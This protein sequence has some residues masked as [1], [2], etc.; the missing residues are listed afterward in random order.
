MSR[1]RLGALVCVAVTGLSCGPLFGAPAATR[2]ALGRVDVPRLPA[3]HETARAAQAAGAGADPSVEAVGE[4]LASRNTGLIREEIDAL[5]R[6]LVAEARR[7]ELDLALVMAVMHVES[8]FHNFA[9]SPAGAVGLMQILPSTGEELARREGVRWRGS[10]TLLEPSTNVRLG[11]AYLRE[12]LDRYDGDLWAALAAYNWGPGH[13]DRRLQEG[14]TLPSGYPSLVWQARAQRAIARV[15][16]VP[17]SSA[18]K[19]S[20]PF[21]AASAEPR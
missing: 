5:A 12:L 16:F 7:H 11:T 20:I 19:R 1:R 6:T 15:S 9:I 4:Y 2:E 21:I 17:T 3:A 8:R 14:V 18:T 10:Q 13:V